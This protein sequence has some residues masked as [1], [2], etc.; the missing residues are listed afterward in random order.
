MKQL[1]K[2]NSLLDLRYELALL[3][4]RVQSLRFTQN[5]CWIESQLKATKE[6]CNE[7]IIGFSLKL[8]HDIVWQFL[9]PSIFEVLK[10]QNEKRKLNKF[11]INLFNLFK[12]SMKTEHLKRFAIK[13]EE[14]LFNSMASFIYFTNFLK[15]YS[16]AS[17]TIQIIKV[18]I[19]LRSSKCNMV[20]TGIW[21]SSFN[22]LLH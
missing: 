17:P 21:Y 11:E 22:I 20:S 2:T 19:S 8:F 14:I 9:F 3:E 16:R 7:H 15:I 13:F 4:T 1:W 10:S 6:K 18:G 5:D 12:F